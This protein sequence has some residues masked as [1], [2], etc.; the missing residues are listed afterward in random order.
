MG[1]EAVGAQGIRNA[2]GDGQFVFH[3]Q[4]GFHATEYRVVLQNRQGVVPPGPARWLPLD[5][6]NALA[7]IRCLVEWGRA[8]YDANASII[9]NTWV[10]TQ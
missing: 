8:I 4:D 1:A 10:S 6:A 9:S 2:V 3:D 5:A 7:S